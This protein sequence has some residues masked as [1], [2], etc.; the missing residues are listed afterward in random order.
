MKKRKSKPD[1][2][3]NQLQIPLLE[4][5]MQDCEHY[6]LENLTLRQENAA[7][8]AELQSLKERAIINSSQVNEPEENY[9]IIAPKH[10][11]PDHLS[12]RTKLFRS[13]FRG[14]D[15]IY[16]ERW[17]KDGTAK[18]SPAKS[19][20]WD[21]HNKMPKGKWKCAESCHPLPFTDLVLKE[22][23]DGRKTVGL[24]PLLKDD[25]CWL[26]AVDFDEENW[27][28]DTRTFLEVC[29]EHGVPAYFE[30]SRSGNG[31]HV[32]IFFDSPVA[33]SQA[34]KL[35]T[36]LVSETKERRYQL[37]FK[38]YDRLFPNQDTLP[39]GGYGNL[40]ALPLQKI[41]S[42][43]GCSVFAD[44]NFVPYKDQWTFL[45]SVVRM[46][47]SD[48]ATIVIEA[49]VKNAIIPVA[50]YSDASDSSEED[51]F[52]NQPWKRKPSSGKEDKNFAGSFPKRL[53]IVL[54]DRIYVPKEEFGSQAL[55]KIMRIAAFQN[56]E[57]YL[58]QATRQSTHDTPRIICCADDL[59]KFIALPRGCLDNLKELF[60]AN[61]IETKER[62]ERNMGL[63][64]RV[65]FKGELRAEQKTASQ[66]IL[67]SNTG[68]LCA[69][70]AFGKTVVAINA[71]AERAV[72][73][74]ILVH[75]T[76]LIDQWKE[77]LEQFLE[78]S[79]DTIGQIGGGKKKRTGLIDIATIQS[80]GRN[81]N[82]SD[83]ITEYGHIIVDEC[84]HLPAF[85]FEQVVKHAKA[86][87]FLGLTATPVRKDGHQ[88][89]IMMQCGPVR[90][91]DKVGNRKNVPGI[92]HSVITRET[93]VM[94]AMSNER[95]DFQAL[96]EIL[97]QDEK[98]NE[99]IFDDILKELEL[100][101]SPLVITE[102]VGHLEFL[103]D[104]LQGFAKNVIVLKGGMTKKQ[105]TQ[106]FENL[107]SIAAG[108]ERII[109]S[110]GKYIG[111][112]FDDA[113]LDTLFLLLPISFDGRV[114]Q[115]AG[116]L[117]REYSGKTQIKIYDYVDSSH[118]MLKKMFEKRCAKYRKLGYEIEG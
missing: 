110:T 89:I 10:S 104:K 13:L 37:D 25:T 76:P 105:R 93:G 51:E 57:F 64:L 21:H 36:F 9:E 17:E 67:S 55:N 32:W 92:N 35:G 95:V 6:R 83:V 26:L 29:D 47:N 16:A 78:H 22:H 96:C 43:N 73:T 11:I 74:L 94:L 40:I 80:L 99:L 117:H 115:Y 116:R 108:T 112:G 71:I 8:R 34:R 100:G 24:Y 97:A 7:L 79:P 33:A 65:T 118:P 85:T 20:D 30:I 56:P 86:K 59:P 41:P 45:K 91:K 113:R 3:P 62:D 44:R 101:R 88:P 63:P 66:S 15:D 114:E 111:E 53:E 61:K 23:L 106:I 82:I 52:T 42:E 12:E 109:L 54:N 103:A 107:K 81:E 14:R 90:Y 1:Q 70:T 5:V 98:R 60:C 77:R 58:K 19:H 75:R 102:R 39:S 27:R 50:K 18:Y 4:N 49:S 69:S 38:S 87:Y 72:N 2:N 46:R 84:H 31:G 48:L 68:I 28:E